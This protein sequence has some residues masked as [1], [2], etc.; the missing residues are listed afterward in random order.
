MLQSTVGL[1][2][3]DHNQGCFKARILS[4]KKVHSLFDAI[5]NKVLLVEDS[6]KVIV[7]ICSTIH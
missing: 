1:S 3:T 6:A 5:I 2:C 4:G 7:V